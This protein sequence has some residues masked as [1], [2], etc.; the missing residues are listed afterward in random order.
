MWEET[1]KNTRRYIVLG[2]VLIALGAL[3]LLQNLGVLNFWGLLPY[4]TIE[5]GEVVAQAIVA[6]LFGGVGLI[7]LVIFVVNVYRNWWAVIP[8]FTLMG[9]AAL[10]AFGNRMGEAGAGM[11]LG[12]IGLSFLVIYLVRREFWWAI[13]PAGVLLTLAVMI[14]MISAFPDA[15]MLVPALLFFGLALTFL[16]VFL[17]PS[18]EERRTWALYPAGILAIIGVLLLLSLGNLINILGGLA[19][20]AGGSYLM[21]RA[22]RR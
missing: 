7:F 13:I 9:L 21:L 5:P 17:L 15:P 8:G 4:I 3:A 18:E 1:V 19:L 11:F 22:F 12:A 10:I 16:L 6:F 2:I 14:P 20:I